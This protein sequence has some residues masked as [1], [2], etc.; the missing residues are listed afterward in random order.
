MSISAPL[1]PEPFLGGDEEER[2]TRIAQLRGRLEG[3]LEELDD[4]GLA[5]TAARFGMAL[6][7]FNSESAEPE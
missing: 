6:D 1:G 7:A 5:L 3:M 2:A 4:L